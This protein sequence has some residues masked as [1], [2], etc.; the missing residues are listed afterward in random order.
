MFQGK[1]EDHVTHGM[2]VTQLLVRNGKGKMMTTKE[3][4]DELRLEGHDF[5]TKTSSHQGNVSST[6]IVLCRK[7]NTPI[8]REGACFCLHEDVEDWF[9]EEAPRLKSFHEIRN[10]NPLKVANVAN[11]W[12]SPEGDHRMLK[13]EKRIN[14]L[15]GPSK[16]RK[17]RKASKVVRFLDDEQGTGDSNGELI[18][19]ETGPE[20]EDVQIFANFVRNVENF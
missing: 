7:A 3:V 4:A 11:G 10:L 17:K 13:S 18:E 20:A 1:M 6:L 9:L 14:F 5:S 12:E 2:L 16:L 19:H 15:S 8:R